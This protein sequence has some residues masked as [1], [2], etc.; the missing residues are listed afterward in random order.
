MN[1]KE[2]SEI[3]RRFRP[4][5]NNISTICGC[6]VNE[7]REIISEFNQ[8]LHLMPSEDAEN[9]LAVLKRTLSGALGK[10]LLDIVFDTKQVVDSEEH[11][12][13]MELRKSALKDE[14]T[15]HTFFQR[16]VDTLAIQGDY[17]ILLT[18]DKYDVPY[19]SKDGEKQD[20]A[21]SEVY[22]Y[23]L[24][25]ICP[26]KI[27][28]PALSYYI[29]QNEFHNCKSDWLVGAPALGFLFPAF[30]DRSADIYSS[31]YYSR[32]TGENHQEFVDAI[33]RREL[34]MPAAAQKETFEAILAD[35]LAE[36]CSLEVIQAVHGQLCEMI[37]E[38]KV[39][40]EVEPL[41]IS[42][43]TVKKVLEARGVSEH[44]VTAFDDKYDAS[45]G[46]DADLSPCNVVDTKQFQL[47]TPDVTINVNPQRSDLVE[48]RIIGGRKYIL[49]R[50]DEGVEVN[51]V[52]INIPND[53]PPHS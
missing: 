34:P 39:N 33:F 18:H 41:V 9:I 4:D 44:H 47:R 26:I 53:L 1:E 24:C 36:D 16:V 43:A 19:R 3:R 21:S 27:T 13:L 45:F 22:S 28:K 35:T 48:T 20:D 38:H 25:S 29:S 23:I 46:A 5:K 6:Y 49:I 10:N 12:M 8:S 2:I 42:K 31:L 32:D 52:N 14:A 30:S 51:G 7:K 37:M 15:V 40:K 50:A 11:R 17:L